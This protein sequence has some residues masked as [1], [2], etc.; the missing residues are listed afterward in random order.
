MTC[1]QNH[2]LVLAIVDDAFEICL[3]IRV[4]PFEVNDFDRISKNNFRLPK[5]KKFCDPRD[6]QIGHII[7]KNLNHHIEYDS[8]YLYDL[9]MFQREKIIADSAGPHVNCF[10]SGRAFPNGRNKLILWC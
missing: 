6:F 1:R 7:D 4:K 3:L 2:K 9:V 10:P 5:G 8:D